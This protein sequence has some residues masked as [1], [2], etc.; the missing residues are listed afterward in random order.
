MQNHSEIRPF[1]IDVPQADLDD[2][3]DRLAR[4]RWAADLPGVGWSRGVPVS[5][6]KELAGYWRDGYDWR[7]HE[8]KLNAFPQFV[9]EIDGQDI[10]FLHVRSPEPGAL[11][12][13]LIHGWPGS[14][15]EFL[16]V[17]G[18]LTD[19]RAHGADP[20]TA[21]HLVIPSIPGTAFSGPTREAGWDT[22][23]ITRAFAELMH[24]L[25]YDRYGA[26]GG[27]T[28]AVV[29]PGLGRLAPDK[30]VG[31]HANGLAAFGAPADDVEL[32]EA[33]K[34]R[35]QH[36]AYLRTEQSGYV[37]MQTTRPQTLAHG[38]HDSPVGQLAWIVEKFKEWTDPA[39]ELPED[40]VDRDLLLTNV[41]LYWLTGTG[42][43]SAN[44]YYETAHA[45]A[46]GASERSPVPTG[47]AVFP[48]D[49]SIR[50]ALDREHTI[51]HWSE[52]GRGGHFAAMEAP[53]LLVDDVRAFF[54]E[55]R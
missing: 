13:I 49:V 35:L 5:Y 16:N 41:M 52:F 19:P 26:Q 31:V 36:F 44:C 39:A 18:P 7:A 43:S 20:A 11:P 42:G 6:L 22:G 46:W 51:V 15:V 30:V 21:F 47:V 8:R 12:L 50:G 4:T 17:I 37:A 1:T 48:L 38:L 45:G 9:T 33:E 14:I 40:A 54:G 2:L 28:G 34:A 29:G 55:L 27:D 25:G 32:T 23:R 3:R 53:D 10:H 24:R